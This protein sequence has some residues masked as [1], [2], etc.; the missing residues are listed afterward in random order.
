VV[1]PGDTLAFTVGTNGV[2]P[3]GKF[4]TS[5]TFDVEGKVKSRMSLPV[6]GVGL[7]E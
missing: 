6:T 3:L 7:V 5:L 2:P 1:D 4:T